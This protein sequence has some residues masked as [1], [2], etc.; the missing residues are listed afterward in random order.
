MSRPPKQEQWCHQ[1]RLTLRSTGRHTA[2]RAWAS[3]HSRP[4]PP[5]RVAP[6]TLNV[7]R[8]KESLVRVRATVAAAWHPAKYTRHALS[9]QF[10][11]GVRHLEERA[12]PARLTNN[13]LRARA[14]A[15]ART[16][17]SQLV[18]PQPLRARKSAAARKTSVALPRGLRLELGTRSSAPPPTPNPSFER[19]HHGSPLQALISFWAL[20]GLP[21]CASQLK[22]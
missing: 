5:R 7:R 3:F 11:A 1:R 17:V 9:R 16:N 19:T 4:S 20:R 2:G 10:E 18:G 12:S 21:R 13:S 14:E 6:V 22:R 8:R 15:R